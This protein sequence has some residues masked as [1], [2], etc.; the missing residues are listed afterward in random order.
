MKKVRIPWGCWYGNK[1]H[2]ITFPKNWEVHVSEMKGAP[3]IKLGAINKAIDEPIYSPKLEELAQGKKTVGII[4]DDITRPTPVKIILPPIIEKLKKAGIREEDI[5]IFI[6]LGSHR[7]MIKQDMIKKLGKKIVSTFQVLNHN[8]FDN[9]IYLGKSKMGH[10]ISINRSFMEKE[11]KVSIGGIL[12]HQLAGFGGGAKN[13]I[14]GI[15]G[16]ETLSANHN[17]IFGK[18][19]EQKLLHFCIGEPDNPLR[20]DMEDIAS[21]VGPVF[22]VNTVLNSKME[23]AGIFAGDSV[24]AHRAGAQFARE[25]YS[26]KVILEA[27]IIILNAYPKDTEFGQIVNVFNVLGNQPK[28]FIRNKDSIIILTTAASEGA[29][30]HSLL[31]PGMK[32]FVPYDSMIPPQS[33]SGIKTWIY[34]PDLSIAEIKSFFVNLPPL[35]NNWERILKALINRYREKAKVAIYP[36]PC[37]Q[38]S[39]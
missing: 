38:M 33:I 36:Y 12:P 21:K 37:V 26:T 35:Y 8:P 19:N 4:V 28:R 6:S 10:P 20:K 23:V 3:T 39:G 24:K 2:V 22:F 14:P 32:M 29:G 13:I 15:G 1:E 16:I 17:F 5:T 25:V 30:F 31:G 18:K 27:D 7:P 34:S 9:L 11:V